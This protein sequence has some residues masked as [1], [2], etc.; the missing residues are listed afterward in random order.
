MVLSSTYRQSGQPR[1]SAE[2]IDAANTLLWRS[3]PRRLE[4]EPIRDAILWVSGNLDTKMG[5]P[6]F[7]LFETN[8]NYVKVYNSKKEFGPP[9]WR[10]MI[11][12]SK[13]RMQVDDTFGS[14]DCPDGGQITPRRNSSTTPLQA[15]NLLNSSFILQ[16]SE[17]FA[18]R[19]QREAGSHADAQARQAFQL[20]F[21]RKPDR[22]ELAASVKLIR[23]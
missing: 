7:D 15:L 4:A 2:K 14:F 23:Q 6:G 20:A 12:Q 17:I 3:A 9:E 8:S 19:L 21:A 1:A 16:Q 22:T 13:W 11:Y 10:R 18:Q 5:G